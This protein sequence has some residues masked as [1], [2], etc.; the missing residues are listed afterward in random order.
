MMRERISRRN[1]IKLGF[2][3]TAGICLTSLLKGCAWLPGETQEEADSMLESHPALP[4][5]N[6]QTY[7]GWH[8]D[9]SVT[10][11]WLHPGVPE[12]AEEGF[13]E[14]R[15]IIDNY[16]KLFG[17][18]PAVHSISDRAVGSG[19][20]PGPIVKGAHSKGVV[21]MIRYYPHR[22]W[23]SIAQG[24][25][26]DSFKAF[27]DSACKVNEPF[28]FTPFP[29]AGEGVGSH[30]WR[31]WNAKYF[32][33][34]WDRMYTIADKA[35]ANDLM[36]WG[37]HLQGSYAS[38]NKPRQYFYVDPAQV[39]M[40][41]VSIYD[42][43]KYGRK[44]FMQLLGPDYHQLTG[45]Y[46]TKPF[47]IWELGTGIYDSAHRMNEKAMG[48]WILDTYDAISKLPRAK[49]VVWYAILWKDHNHSFIVGDATDYYRR[50][51]SNK[52]FI[53]A[54]T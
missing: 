3:A 21:P 42:N 7:T 1:F 33:P 37:L 24:V 29:E 10:Y 13:E 49:L 17:Q 26:D 45:Q 20:F 40:V 50:A 30:P 34:A 51:I 28:V 44:S 52:H 8:L 22:D 15:R 16:E 53:G 39:N 5:L 48:K 14:E 41:G 38:K 23:K 27:V 35:K 25:I 2:G 9:V 36:L 47:A 12:Q 4:I 32:K 31:N 54:K 18:K 6:G 43:P 11:R 46:E 19:Y